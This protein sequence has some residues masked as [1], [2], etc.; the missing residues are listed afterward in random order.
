MLHTHTGYSLRSTFMQCKHHSFS[1]FCRAFVDTYDYFTNM[2][3]M[4]KHTEMSIKVLGNECMRIICIHLLTHI[5]SYAFYIYMYTSPHKV[6]HHIH[7]EFIIQFTILYFMSIKHTAS[8]S[9]YPS[10]L[11]L[12]YASFSSLTSRS[13]SPIVLIT[14][15]YITGL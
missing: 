7:I 9:P 15:A 12:D 8:T 6:L 5:I 2:F 10:F 4:K 14:R 13:I 1:S 11:N 3:D